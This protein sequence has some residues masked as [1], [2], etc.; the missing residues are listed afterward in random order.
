[1]VRVTALPDQPAFFLLSSHS[2]LPEAG[3]G[4]A[5]RRGFRKLASPQ[6]SIKDL[7]RRRQYL[8]PK[9]AQMDWGNKIKVTK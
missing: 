2:P 6:T 1:M 3:G 9:V 5:G 4:V 8:F 7:F